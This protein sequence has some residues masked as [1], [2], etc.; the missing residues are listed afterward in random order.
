MD[1]TVIVATYGEGRWRELAECRAIPA[2]RAEAEVIAVHG[3]TLQS[4][5]NAGAAQATSEWLCFCDADDEVEPGYMA[6]MA[7]LDADLRA[8]LVRYVKDHRHWP[9]RVP[10]GTDDLADGNRL[11]IGTLVR[12][13][14]FWRV[15]GFG[16]WAFYEDWD[17]WQRCWLAGATVEF[18]R[19]I[20]RAHMRAD[21][22][23]RSPSRAEKVA[24]HHD[25]RRA[26]MPWLY[27]HETMP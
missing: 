3:E 1:V 22:R 6:A 21:S 27:E 26:N 18:G 10:D 14:M 13:E 16:G 24:M 9:A 15:G 25:I 4:A 5:R 12:R 23:N 8:P 20:Y 19:A 11:V 17:L 2:A 7:E